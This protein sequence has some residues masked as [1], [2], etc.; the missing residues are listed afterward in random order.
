MDNTQLP[1]QKM[2]VAARNVDK[3]LAI[4]CS[5]PTLLDLMNI[6]PPQCSTASGLTDHDY[7]V[8]SGAP[9]D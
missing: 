4:D 6:H 5:A 8:L 1:I 9:R 2:E 7:P 3:S